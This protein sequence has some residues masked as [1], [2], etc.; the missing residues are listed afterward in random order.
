MVDCIKCF[1]QVKK[2]ATWRQREFILNVINACNFLQV[3]LPYTKNVCI[4]NVLAFSSQESGSFLLKTSQFVNNE[5]KAFLVWIAIMEQDWFGYGG[6]VSDFS[7]NW[8]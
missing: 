8:V 2:Y 5:V 1:G 6:N 7:F 3:G 4:T